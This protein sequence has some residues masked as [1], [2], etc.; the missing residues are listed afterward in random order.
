MTDL[1]HDEQTLH[2]VRNALDAAG[3]GDRQITDAINQMQSA[4]ILFRERDNR[5]DEP[6]DL[7]RKASAQI[8]DLRADRDKVLAERDEQYDQ[9]KQLANQRDE[10]LASLVEEI[11][12][13]VKDAT[14]EIAQ[15]RVRIDKQ[16]D[17]IKQLLNERDDLADKLEESREAADLAQ[18]K[19][20]ELEAV[21]MDQ[22][23]TVPPPWPP[24]GR[25]RRTSP[26][27]EGSASR[28]SRSTSR[29]CSRSRTSSSPA[30]ATT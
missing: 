20:A 5:P 1:T 13:T 27:Q 17:R 8:A 18:A 3:L 15:V 12:H 4:G 23:H 9:L 24:P 16:T 7:L 30:S 22:Q 10:L 28:A 29:H 26:R 19:V 14:E 11:R 25:P 2:K 6:G 21:P